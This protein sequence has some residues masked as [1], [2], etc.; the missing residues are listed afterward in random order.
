MP[1]DQTLC[2]VHIAMD[3][4]LSSV[5]AMH[6]L[7]EVLGIEAPE[8]NLSGNKVEILNTV[9]RQYVKCI[10]FQNIQLLAQ[11]YHGQ[12]HMPLWPEIKE[13]MLAGRGG[14]CF[15]VGV[16]MKVLLETLG[17]DVYFVPCKIENPS[18]HICTVVRNLSYEGSEHLIDVIGYP[19]FEK[20]PLDFTETSP[21]YN[22]SFCKHYFKRVGDKVIQRHNVKGMDG[23][24]HIFGTFHLVPQQLPQFFPAMENIYTNTS[25]SHFLQEIMAISFREGKCV[26]IR[27]SA[28]LEE[29]E[30]HALQ[31]SIIDHETM[32]TILKAHF[33]QIS[34]TVIENAVA[35]L[36]DRQV[37]GH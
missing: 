7:K 17:Y 28:F 2:H 11:A 30:S 15:T 18:D 22:Y 37:A 8:V 4:T 13:D 6:F 33:P 23:K 10:P 31:K 14:I 12:N 35:Y 3:T 29:D 9:V 36:K 19:N 5:E 16:F 27:G 26:A 21:V 24:E 20:F 32:D 1:S 34:T 25:R